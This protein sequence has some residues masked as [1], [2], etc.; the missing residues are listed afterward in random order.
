MVVGTKSKPVEN[1][2]PSSCNV[3]IAVFFSGATGPLLLISRR[4]GPSSNAALD[5]YSPRTSACLGNHFIRYGSTFLCTA[6]THVSLAFFMR[7]NILD[8]FRRINELHEYVIQSSDIIASRRNHEI[9]VRP[10]TIVS[11][12]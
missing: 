9:K 10:Y 5:L 1:D 6:N 7:L 8:I 2:P 11:Q 3:T 4:L 12:S